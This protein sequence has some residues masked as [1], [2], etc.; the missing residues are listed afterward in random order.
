MLKVKAKMSMT[1]RKP[2]GGSSAGSESSFNG[3]DAM[4]DLEMFE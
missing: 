2:K 1:V 3:I 4:D